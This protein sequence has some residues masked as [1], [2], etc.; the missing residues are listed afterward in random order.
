MWRPLEMRFEIRSAII[1]CCIRLHNYCINARLELEDELKKE[2]GFIEVVPGLE[3]LAP[4]VNEQRASVDHM[5][6]EC[7]C[8]NCRQTS[9]IKMKADP[10]RRTELENDVRDKGIVRPERRH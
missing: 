1:G 2:D 3:L 9:R 6:T 8:V 7:H 5:H 10:S 4:R